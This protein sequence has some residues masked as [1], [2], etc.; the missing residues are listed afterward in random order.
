VA[1]REEY[2]IYE[3]IFEFEPSKGVEPFEGGDAETSSAG[4]RGS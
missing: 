2:Q 3:I 1:Y 4:Q